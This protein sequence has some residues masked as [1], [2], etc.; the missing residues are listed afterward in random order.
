MK[1]SSSG[2]TQQEAYEV[3]QIDLAFA[4]M[5]LNY[6]FFSWSGAEGEQLTWAMWKYSSWSA[7]E[8]CLCSIVPPINTSAMLPLLSD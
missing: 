7:K 8:A 2:E 1:H 4:D 3:L 6:T 5:K